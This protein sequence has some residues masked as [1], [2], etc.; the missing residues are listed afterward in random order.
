MGGAIRLDIVIRK[1]KATLDFSTPF[2][3]KYQAPLLRG[4]P[5]KKTSDYVIDLLQVY[6][7]AKPDHMR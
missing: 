4:W 5:K 1:G 3:R 6:V 2:H 7:L